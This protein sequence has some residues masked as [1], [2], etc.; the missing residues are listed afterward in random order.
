VKINVFDHKV[1]KYTLLNVIMNFENLGELKGALERISGRGFIK[2]HRLNNTGIGKTLEDEMDITE[3]NY[4]GCD[5][6]LGEKMVELKAQRKHASSRV[7]LTTKEPLWSVDKLKT[8]KELGYPDIQGRIGLKIT[9]SMTRPSPQGFS[10]RLSDGEIQIISRKKGKICF[11]KIKDLME[12]LKHKLGENLLFVLAET[13]Y[14]KEK[15]EEHFHYQDAVLFS[16]LNEKKF[17]ELLSSGKIIWEFRLH[18]KP[19]GA[20]RDHGSGFRMNRK[21]L[22]ELFNKQEIIISLKQK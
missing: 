16:G 21:H 19:S 4:A 17:R 9:I 18:I 3:N 1:L 22:G 20:I 8:I 6:K 12:I 10:M 2:S 5:F 15:T 11:Y 14:G 7:T 13:K